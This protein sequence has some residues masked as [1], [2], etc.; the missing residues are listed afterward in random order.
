MLTPCDDTLLP[1]LLSLGEPLFRYHREFVEQLRLSVSEYGFVLFP[2][3][4]FYQFL[5]SKVSI[6]DKKITKGLAVIVNLL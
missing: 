2:Y 1:L 4:A 5:Q 6:C 3:R